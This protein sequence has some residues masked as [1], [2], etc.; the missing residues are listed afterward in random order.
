MYGQP[1]DMLSIYPTLVSLAG[2][3]DKPDLDGHDLTPLLGDPA[4]DWSYPAITIHGKGNVAIRSQDW[5]CIQYWDGGGRNCMIIGAILMN[6][7]IWL[8]IVSTVM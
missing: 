8:V 4:M 6:G 3:L 1:V 2:L 5:R 7:Q